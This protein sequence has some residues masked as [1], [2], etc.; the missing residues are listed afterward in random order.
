MSKKTPLIPDTVLLYP[1]ATRTL[2]E[3]DIPLVFPV[4]ADCTKKR[5][6]AAKE[7]AVGW[8][9]NE[10]IPPKSSEEV[11]N[12]F[13]HIDI[14]TI[15][16]R[17][18]GGRA[19]KAILEDK[20]GI[21]VREDIMMD[22]I[23]NKGIK[24][25]GRITGPFVFAQV[26]SQFKLI[27]QGSQ[28]YKHV[29]TQEASKNAKKLSLIQLVPGHVYRTPGNNYSLYLGRFWQLCIRTE[30]TPWNSVK[31]SVTSFTKNHQFLELSYKTYCSKKEVLARINN[32]LK[33]TKPCPKKSS[34]F[35]EDCGS[36]PSALFKKVLRQKQGYPR[37]SKHMG[38]D[39]SVYRAIDCLNTSLFT[40]DDSVLP[41]EGWEDWLQTNT[42]RQID[43]V[44]LKKELEDLEQ[45]RT[46][47][48]HE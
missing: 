27:R 18:E 13:S 22:C 26:H 1:H 35:V 21:D 15:E 24:R 8:Y 2:E 10:C 36:I 20:W 29:M 16:K 32:S 3:T 47:P 37:L 12:R 14:Q 38:T 39:D 28:L 7:W 41:P 44:R 46:C 9:R 42:H 5:K 48:T 6:Q 23:Q 30:Y 33:Y 31:Y 17:A 34:S 45:Q 11:S 4:P 19:Y 40:D 43:T 25:G